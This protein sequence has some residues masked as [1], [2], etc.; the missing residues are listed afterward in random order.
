MADD[1]DQPA[2]DDLEPPEIAEKATGFLADKVTL[3]NPKLIV[4]A[5][6]AGV[7]IA[8]G[9]LFF[10]VVI[11]ADVAAPFGLLQLLGGI[12]FSLGL[13][14]VV[15][16]GAELF[17]GNTLMVGLWAQRV[18]RPPAILRAWAWAWCGNFLG[19]VAVVVLFF[20]AQGHEAGDSQVGLAALETAEG[21]TALP[22]WAT[23]SSGILANMLVCL[24]VWL[25]LSARTTPGKIAAIVLPIAAF[26]AAG[27]EHSVANM[28]LI[29]MGLI[30]KLLAGDGFW[31]AIDATAA[32][33]PT[34]TWVWMLWN[35]L[36]A[37]LGNILGGAIIA[38]GYWVAYSREAED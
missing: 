10:L 18:H 26:V 9:G 22:F 24:A 25:A 2:M 5:L 31:L 27:L 19:S 3:E 38:L 33:F 32:D 16:G 1:Q 17:T 30:V 29:P 14:L 12:A 34:L 8:F 4:L 7:Y 36:W 11:A 37:T 28:S 21:K 20:L 35:I 6:L 13:V 23:L 15:V